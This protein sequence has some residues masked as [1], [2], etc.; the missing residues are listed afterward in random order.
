M[1]QSHPGTA[2]ITGASSGI[3]AL[4]AERLAH[5]GYDLILVARNRE[6][7]NAL[8]KRLTDETGRSVEVVE[9]DLGNPDDLR[10]VELLLRTDASITLLVNNAGVGATQPLLES[11]VDK[12]QDMITLNVNVLTRLTYAAVP[13]LVARQGTLI[14]IASVV[15]LAP[16]RLNGVYGGTKAF[17][18]AFSQSLHHELADKHVRVQVVLPGATATDFW[19]AAGTPLDYLPGEIV[20]KADDMVD[21][22]LAG[23]D[24][25]EFITI[26]SLPDLGD[27]ERYEAARQALMPNLSLRTPATRYCS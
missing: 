23:L 15:A 22:A 18:L 2:L 6:R 20:M 24:Q 4:Y 10:Q 11:D 3:G 8:A 1:T 14:N 25:G 13:G 26:P 5:R 27:L 16:E 12:M 9:A 7:L 17:V 19:A 21:A